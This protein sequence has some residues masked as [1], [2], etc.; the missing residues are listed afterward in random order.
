[1]FNHIHSYNNDLNHGMYFVLCSS[2]VPMTTLFWQLCKQ[3]CSQVGY[4]YDPYVN[5]LE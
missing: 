5:E 2:V 4:G 1:M 3:A